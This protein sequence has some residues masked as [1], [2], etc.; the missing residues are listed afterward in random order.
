[1]IQSVL[2]FIGNKLDQLGWLEWLLIIM[3]LCFMYVL[4][5]AQMADDNFDLRHL[6]ADPSTDKLVLEKFCLFGAF[7]IS[8]W[9][10]VALI[11]KNAITEWYFI[12]YMASWAASRSFSGWLRYKGT[13]HEP[14]KA[15]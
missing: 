7:I 1:M 10:F 11:W 3:L 6:V 13:G 9:G 14:P 8:S 12:G 2:T 15:P 4:Y 5:R